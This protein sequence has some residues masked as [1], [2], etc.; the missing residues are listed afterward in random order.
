MHALIQEARK[1]NFKIQ[2]VLPEL[3]QCYE[4][5]IIRQNEIYNIICLGIEMMQWAQYKRYCD[6]VIQSEIFAANVQEAVAAMTA[7][8]TKAY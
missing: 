3:A 7:Q 8:S 1:K 4:G 2:M 6:I 5:L